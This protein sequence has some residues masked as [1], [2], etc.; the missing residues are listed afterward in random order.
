MVHVRA[1]FHV[2][3][4][5]DFRLAA[6]EFVTALVLQVAGDV[7]ISTHLRHPYSTPIPKDAISTTSLRKKNCDRREM[8]NPHLVLEARSRSALR[9]WPHDEGC[10]KLREKIGKCTSGSRKSEQERENIES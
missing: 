8:C 4:H 2:E 7:C 1:Q 9:A 6:R 10:S 3:F 5:V